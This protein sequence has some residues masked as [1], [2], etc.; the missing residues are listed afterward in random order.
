MGNSFTT[1][2]LFDGATPTSGTW[3][4]NP[5][6][7]SR[8]NN[9]WWVKVNLG[10]LYALTGVTVYSLGDTT[11][12]PTRFTLHGCSSAVATTSDCSDSIATCTRSSGTTSGESCSFTGDWQYVLFTVTNTAT[13]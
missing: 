9:N 3:G 7:C 10:T 1:N 8:Y 6:G 11:H 2:L 5:T 4:W 12:D 13:G